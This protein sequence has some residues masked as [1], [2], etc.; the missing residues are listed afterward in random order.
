M[1]ESASARLMRWYKQ[2][3]NPQIKVFI[4]FGVTVMWITQCV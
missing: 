3:E 2:Q 1:N 4:V